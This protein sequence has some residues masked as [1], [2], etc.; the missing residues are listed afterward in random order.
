MGWYCCLPR[1][2]IFQLGA[3]CARRPG[4]HTRRKLWLSFLC[5]LCCAAQQGGSLALQT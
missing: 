2:A 1:L 3:A 4:R 5:V